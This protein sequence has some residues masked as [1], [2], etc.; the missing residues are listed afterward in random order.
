MGQNSQ[1]DLPVLALITA[2]PQRG[3]EVALEHAE[4]GLCLP[5]LT[6]KDLREVLLHP[7]AVASPDRVWLAI[8]AG[9]APISGRNDTANVLSLATKAM[10]AF[11]FVAGVA[12]QRPQR[13]VGDRLLDRR[14]AFRE[15]GLGAPIGHAPQDHMVGGIADHRELGIAAFLVALVLFTASGVVCRDVPGLQ[16]GRVDGRQRGPLAQNLRL[17]AALEDPVQQRLRF[18]FRQQAFAGGPQG[19]KMGHLREPQNIPQFGPFRQQHPDAAVV[20]LAELFD[21]QTG[22]QLRLGELV[23]ALAMAIVGQALLPRFQRFSRYGQS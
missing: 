4:D 7:P 17:A 16:T 23:R 10:E 21:H 12:Q 14:P 18:R 22:E 6:V 8:G 20:Q 9:T 5:T 2:G 15:I 13:L 19:G 1:A 11:R 3:A